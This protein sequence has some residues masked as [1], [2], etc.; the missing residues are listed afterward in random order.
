MWWWVL[1]AAVLVLAA[2]GVLG[3]LVW[4]LVRKGVAVAAEL[5]R[6]GERAA[7]L[8]AQVERLP[9]MARPEPSVFD[10]PASLRRARTERLRRARAARQRSRARVRPAG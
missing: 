5:G 9:A 3:A 4:G 7:E 10:D 6:A 2:A 1:V 8:S